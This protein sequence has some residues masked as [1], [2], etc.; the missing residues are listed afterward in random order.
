VR[1]GGAGAT[2]L[3]SPTGQ[4]NLGLEGVVSK[5]RE[6][7][8]QFRFTNDCFKGP[9]ASARRWLSPDARTRKTSLTAFI[10]RGPVF[11]GIRQ[12]CYLVSDKA[13]VE[14]ADITDHRRRE[15]GAFFV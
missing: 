4:V 15:Q 1:R 9:A 11:K 14:I 6:C 13:V 8:L 3:T 7:S 12:N 2:E 10:M 5:S